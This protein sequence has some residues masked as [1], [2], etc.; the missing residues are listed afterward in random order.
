MFIPI[1]ILAV[2]GDIDNNG[3]VGSS[4]YIMIR[5]HILGTSK[6]TGDNLTKADVNY[7]GK[8]SVQDYVII[9]KSIINGTTIA[10][11]TAEPT[12]T[13]L[14]SASSIEAYF[15]NTINRKSYGEDYDNND[16]FIFKTS[17]GKYILI[18]TGKSPENIEKTIYNELKSLQDNKTKVTLDYMILSHMHSDHI[19]NAKRIIKDAN[20]DIKNLIIKRESISEADESIVELAKKKKINVIE[21]NSLKEGTY[22]ELSSNIKMYLFN[23]KDVYENDD[24]SYKDY[25][26]AITAGKDGYTYLKAKNKDTNKTGYIYF[27]GKEYVNG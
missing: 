20:F 9:R 4:D 7:D 18:D 25:V 11:P 24:C 3:K 13:S 16:A 10:A 26:I 15:L 5:K 17:N 23:V 12:A 22:I 8:V 21:T 27:E 6:L 2:V 14:G 19:G 1:S